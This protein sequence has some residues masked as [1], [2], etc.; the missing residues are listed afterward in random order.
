MNESGFE[1]RSYRIVSSQS[2]GDVSR[3]FFV[4]E[5][6]CVFRVGWKNFSSILLSGPWVA[7]EFFRDSHAMDASRGTSNSTVELP[8]P[9]LFQRQSR[10]GAQ[11]NRW[12]C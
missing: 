8:V 1:F 12:W 3:M 6:N 11:A 2:D 4:T 9:T 5:V 10:A 7:D